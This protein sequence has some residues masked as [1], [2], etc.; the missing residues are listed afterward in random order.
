[1]AQSFTTFYTLLTKT[2]VTYSRSFLGRFYLLIDIQYSSIVFI[3][4]N[5]KENGETQ[6]QTTFAE[7]TP[8][9]KTKFPKKRRDK[10]KRT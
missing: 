7:E 6:Q 3:Y 4:I 1:V 8:A 10:I 5:C 2:K 9:K